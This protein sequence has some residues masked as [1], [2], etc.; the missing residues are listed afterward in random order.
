MVHIVL[1]HIVGSLN[2][3]TMAKVSWHMNGEPREYFTMKHWY[4]NVM[5]WIFHETIE[6][7]MDRGA[8]LSL[9]EFHPQRRTSKEVRVMDPS[10]D[11]VSS[12]VIHNSFELT[13]LLEL[14]TLSPRSSIS[15]GR[16]SC[17]KFPPLWSTTIFDNLHVRT[18]RLSYP[19][20][21][22]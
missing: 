20:R 7:C 12:C 4:M 22:Y 18:R 3:R 19:R 9:D 2:F 5:S 15:V 14:R 10:T 8:D 16:P 17:L 13:Y 1:S 11:R 6:K 21:R